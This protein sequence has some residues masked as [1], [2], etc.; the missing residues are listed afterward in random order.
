M[1]HADP[2][3]SIRKMFLS[4][5][6]VGIVLGLAIALYSLFGLKPRLTGLSDQLISDLQSVDEAT[7]SLQGPGRLL[8]ETLKS[9][10]QTLVVASGALDASGQTAKESKKG[11][12]GAV[13][14]KKE[15]AQTNVAFKETATQL[16]ALAD[17]VD[18]IESASTGIANAARIRIQETQ[19]AIDRASIPIH[20]SMI[21]FTLGGLYVF[22]GLCSILLGLACGSVARLDIPLSQKHR[23]APAAGEIRPRGR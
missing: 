17:K 8:A 2:F 6:L 18:R 22:L 20:A 19:H 1:K 15:L 5:G 23:D 7:A 4:I 3:Q 10:R 16:R 21:G 9:L 14:P 12:I 11:L 13:M